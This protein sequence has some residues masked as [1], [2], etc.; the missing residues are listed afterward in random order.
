MAITKSGTPSPS[1]SAS[2]QSLS[3]AAQSLA[4]ALG[5]SAA[6]G[7]SNYAGPVWMPGAFLGLGT[8]RNPGFMREGAQQRPQGPRGGFIDGDQAAGAYYNWTQKQRD[9]FRAKAMVGGLLKFGDGDLEAGSLWQKLVTQASNYGAQN[10]QIS[11]LDILSGYVK[12]NSNG[13]QWIKQGNF[14]VNAVTG[15]RRYVG[16]QFKT[17]TATN[18]NMTDPATVKAITNQIFQQLLGRDPGADEIQAYANALSQAEIADPSRTTTTTQYDMT[19]GDPT[20][21][22]SVS[23]GGLDAAGQQQ[24]AMDQIKK[25]PEYATTQAVTTYQNALEAAVYGSH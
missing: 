25:K 1:P 6:A 8:S 17:T 4:Q 3:A 19:T 10:Q 7:S 18:V 12:A 21:T 24:L 14:E 13:S 16:P 15:E 20:N 9:D 22:S 11:P 23:V 2:G 5:Q